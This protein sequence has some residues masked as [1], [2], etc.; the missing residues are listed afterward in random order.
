MLY[1]VLFDPWRV[2]ETIHIDHHHGVALA[3]DSAGLAEEV[4][5]HFGIEPISGQI[6]RA[7]K[8]LEIGFRHGL[9]HPAEAPAARTVAIAQTR[10]IGMGG[11]AHGAAMALAL[12]ILLFGHGVLL[13]ETKQEQ[14]LPGVK[15]DAI[16]N[17][18]T[19]AASLG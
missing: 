1:R 17:S 6:V 15:R 18:S 12:T 14:I 16:T 7:R 8:Q 5:D 9:H 4:V 13:C 3:I 2:F 19:V 10:K 11:K